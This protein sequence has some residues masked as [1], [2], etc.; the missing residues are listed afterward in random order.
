MD[1]SISAV[2]AQ[3]INFAII[4]GLFSKFAAKPLANAI[5]DRRSLLEKL[6]HADQAFNQKIQEAEKEAETIIAEANKTKE[7]II[8]EA[9]ILANKKQRE[10]I[11][12]AEIK[13]GSIITDAEH[14]AH[15]LQD[16]LQKDFEKAL[17]Q[18][19]LMVVKKLIDSDTDIQSKYLETVIKDLK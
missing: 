8:N 18:T 16:D 7:S 3:I 2:I 1:I 19:S 13:A 6:K 11:A 10:I 15:A 5:E 9:G 17:K 12:E 14:R 4:F